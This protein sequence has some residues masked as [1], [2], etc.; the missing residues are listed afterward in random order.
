MGQAAE[1]RGYGNDRWSESKD[2]AIFEVVRKK[3]L[4]AEKKEKRNEF[5]AVRGNPAAVWLFSGL[6]AHPSTANHALLL[7]LYQR[8]QWA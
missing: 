6:N 8:Y 7:H 5:K 2:W 4:E 1:Y 3:R